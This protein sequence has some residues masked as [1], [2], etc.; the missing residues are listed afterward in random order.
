MKTQRIFSAVFLTIA[1]IFGNFS[2]ALAA[3]PLPSSF[4]GTVTL[5]GAAVPA[6][7][8]VSARINGVQYASV[9]V[10][11]NSGAAY[12]SLKVP[13]DDPETPGIIEGGVS[14]NTVAFYIG[15]YRADQTAT[16]QSGPNVRVDLTSTTTHTLS[17]SKTGDGSGTVTSAPAG[18]DCGAACSA[19]F[20]RDSVVELTAAAELGSTFTGW[21]GAGCT[22]TGGCSV[23]MDAAKSVTANFTEN[24]YTLTVISAHGTVT[25]DPDDLH[26][27][28][29]DEVTLSVAAD[30]GWTF[31]GWT[32]ALTDNKV[33]ING[34]TTV[35][36]NYTQNEYTLTVVSAHGTVTK[37][38]NQLTYHYGDEVT[39]SVT[40]DAGWTFT[41]WTPVLTDNKV[42][43]NGD[44]TV[45]ANYTQNEYTLTVVSA[46]GTVTKSPNQLT[47]HYGDEVTLSV[48]ADAGWTFTGW[49]PALTDNKVTINGN[50]TV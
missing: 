48:A 25:K 44:T 8:M 35:T 5:D 36:A 30:A 14:G 32:P 40:A 22:G 13:G 29:G 27:H 10:T 47:Y 21:S 3:P 41:G 26:Y 1:L 37:S 38:P 2:T 17:V 23:T 46:H 19:S 42:T 12:Y 16:W 50:T 9:A 6:G 11:I 31:T 34:N 4:W 24:E 49:T 45:T 20:T 43:I 18:I 15:S 28:Y 39:L 7:T 33:T